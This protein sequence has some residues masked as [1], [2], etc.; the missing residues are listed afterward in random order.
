MAEFSV[1]FRIKWDGRYIA[2]LSPVLLTNNLTG[3]NPLSYKDVVPL[4][5][6]VRED[7]ATAVSGSSPIKSGS[8][9]LERL[10]KSP[11]SVSIGLSG[12]GGQNHITIGL[13]AQKAGVD[14]SKL[15]I[16]GFDGSS[17]VVT[18]VLG[19]HVDVILGTFLFPQCCCYDKPAAERHWERLLALYQRRL[20]TC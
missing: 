20:H 6:L 4:S 3:A 19:G 16:V 13:V 8:D 17:D 10:K 14:P 9:L 12:V 15:K 1:K 5:I 18:A 11:S 7:I 2:V